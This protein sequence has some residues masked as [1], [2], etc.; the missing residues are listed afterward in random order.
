MSADFDFITLWED[1]DT[2]V[3]LESRGR[4]IE[5]PMV[6]SIAQRWGV[7]AS[8]EQEWEEQVA[9]ES[10]AMMERAQVMADAAAEG[11]TATRF[12]KKSVKLAAKGTAGATK[13]AAKGT[14]KGAKAV[15][16]ATGKVSVALAGKFKEWAAHYGPKFKAKLHEMAE[17]APAVEKKRQKLERKLDETK[18]LSGNPIKTMA[19]VSCVCL[20]DKVDLD[21]CLYLANHTG[22]LNDAVKQYTVKVRQYEGLLV[23]R[24][25]EQADGTLSKI[26][27][28]SNTAIHRASG[29]L[30]RFTQNDVKA[31][32]M[33]GNVIIV[34]HGKGVK[35]KIEFAV[36]RDTKIGATIDPLSHAECKT[37]LDAVGHLAKALEAR[38]ARHGVFSYTGIYHEMEEMQKKMD[39]M[40]GDELRAAM[41]LYKNSMALEDAFT[42]AMARVSDGLLNWV[43]AS[44]KG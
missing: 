31:R 28:P 44:L 33:A 10:R 4:G 38:G 14:A 32:P 41:L 25:V 23:G 11:K 19:W 13:L 9:R 20:L 21:A 17:K 39:D 7:L 2:I 43:A 35:E 37:A 18:E 34:N 42:T 12:A 3:A 29:F 5:D 6:R 15:G 36:A 24:Y 16:K 8:I 26:G 30:G 40:E 22:A 27:R 1:Y